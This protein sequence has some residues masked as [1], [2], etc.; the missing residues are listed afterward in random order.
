MFDFS[1]GNWVISILEFTELWIQ[2][3]WNL[4]GK[5]PQGIIWFQ[6][7]VKHSQTQCLGVSSWF[8][9]CYWYC[10]KSS[11]TI[12]ADKLCRSIQFNVRATEAL[13]PIGTFLRCGTPQVICYIHIEAICYIAIYSYWSDGPLSSLI[14]LPKMVIFHSFFFFFQGVILRITSFF[15]GWTWSWC[16]VWY[17]DT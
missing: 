17:C 11:V 5:A 15:R 14:C 1:R 10:S 8:S 2:Y 13:W 9:W 12:M 16:R 6:S 7:D 4:V 3:P